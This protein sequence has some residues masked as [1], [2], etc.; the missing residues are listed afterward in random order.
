[1]SPGFSD[2]VQGPAGCRLSRM[3]SA[4]MAKTIL[5][6]SVF[7]LYPLFRLAW[8]YSHADHK[9][10]REEVET[11]KRFLSLSLC[12]VCCYLIGQSKLHGTPTVSVGGHR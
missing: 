9:E 1:M 5:L 3:A 2:V 10:V 12:Q 11:S 7:M 8:S 4:E 6:S